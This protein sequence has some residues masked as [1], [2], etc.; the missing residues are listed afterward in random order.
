LGVPRP[1]GPTGTRSAV[2]VTALGRVACCGGSVLAAL[3]PLRAPP[4]AHA[5]A[6]ARLRAADTWK[7][8]SIS[9]CSRVC[10]AGSSS[11]QP[12]TSCIRPARDQHPPASS[13][14]PLRA[15]QRPCTIHATRKT[16]AIS[17]RWQSLL[18]HVDEGVP[19]S[20]EALPRIGHRPGASA[21]FTTTGCTPLAARHGGSAGPTPRGSRRRPGRPR[22]DESVKMWVG[23]ARPISAAVIAIERQRSTAGGRSLGEQLAASVFPF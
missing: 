8:N 18:K 6:F 14:R 5:V 17:A 10:A 3:G 16:W 2:F 22:E 19:V 21:T 12:S 4:P 13:P 11:I 9:C 23:P 1:R 15:F 7:R 20:H